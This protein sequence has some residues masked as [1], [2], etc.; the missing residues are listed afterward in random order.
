MKLHIAALFAVLT[1][2]MGLTACEKKSESSME[3]LEDNVKDAF[4]ARPHEKM[5][6]AAEDAGDA[7]E[8]AGEAAKEA[9][10]PDSSN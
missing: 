4:D 1:L 10:T 9:V 5:K 3:K 8:E 7:I 2:G 6:D